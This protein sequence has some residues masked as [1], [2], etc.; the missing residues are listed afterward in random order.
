VDGPSPLPVPPPAS[1]ETPPLIAQVTWSQDPTTAAKAIFIEATRAQVTG[2]DLS[3]QPV[4]LFLHV[5]QYDEDSE[6]YV[7]YRVILVSPQQTIWQ[8]TIRAP[9]ISLT[10]T[11]HVLQ[12][13]LF[14]QRLPK[15]DGYEWRVEGQTQSDWQPVG[16][17]L[18][19][20]ATP[21]R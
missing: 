3:R 16:R 6:P 9:K 4:T 15:A 11:G 13:T 14:P 5:P 21:E 1:P 20:P 12:V 19:Q 2:I 8:Q 17:A 18:I 7:R 10:E